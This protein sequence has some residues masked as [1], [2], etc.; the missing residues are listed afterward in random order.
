MTKKNLTLHLD[1]ERIRQAK[2]LAAARGTSVSAMF[3]NWIRAL[4]EPR[5]DPR[6][7]PITKQTM[8]I[9]KLSQADQRKTDRQLIEE[10]IAEKYGI[11][12][13]KR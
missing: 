2:A 11:K 13:R 1:A 5:R 12:P 10:A 4:A 7:G 3:S 8:G 6:I 9:A